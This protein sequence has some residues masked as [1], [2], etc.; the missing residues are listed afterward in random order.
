MRRPAT[1]ARNR[2]RERETKQEEREIGGEKYGWEGE[3][4]GRERDAGA[5][6]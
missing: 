4:E 5:P 6:F 3:R 2:R 1:T